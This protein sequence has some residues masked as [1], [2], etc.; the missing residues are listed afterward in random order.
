MTIPDVL[1]CAAG[2]CPIGSLG[3]G[4]CQRSCYIEACGF[5]K[6]DCDGVEFYELEDPSACEATGCNLDFI[7]DGHCEDS[8]F[9]DACEIDGG[10]CEGYPA[11]CLETDCPMEYVGDGYCDNVCNNSACKFDRGD[12]ESKDEYE[13]GSEYQ[14][15]AHRLLS[16]NAKKFLRKRRID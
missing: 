11:A 6:G 13:Y 16:K 8:C 10:D 3:N 5:D 15:V 4:V 1:L 7:G 12:C 2:G 9:N 14:I